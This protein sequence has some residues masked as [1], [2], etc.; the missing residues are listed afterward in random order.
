MV[1][2]KSYLMLYGNVSDKDLHHY[3]LFLL[4]N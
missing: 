2:G 1:M 3:V 4:H